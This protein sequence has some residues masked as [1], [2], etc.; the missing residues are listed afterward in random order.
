MNKKLNQNWSENYILKNDIKRELKQASFFLMETDIYK[1][2]SQESRT[3][4]TL[5]FF[6]NSQYKNELQEI[7][8]EAKRLNNIQ[9][10]F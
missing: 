7:L 5:D 10:K 1:M 9:N 6:L 3:I 8:K 4:V 2:Y